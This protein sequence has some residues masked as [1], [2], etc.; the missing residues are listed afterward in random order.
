MAD[1]SREERFTVARS[2]R[3]ATLGGT[4]RVEEVW[5]VLHGYGQLA[6]FFMR[7]FADVAAP[8]RLVVAPEALSRFYL[9]LG[10]P[11]IGASWMT[12]EDREQ[13]IEDYV[14]YLDDVAERLVPEDAHL[15]VLGFSQGGATAARWSALGHRPPQ[16]VTLY[17]SEVPPDLDLAAHGTRLPNL[18]LVYGSD[19][20]YVSAERTARTE[21]RLR[22]ADVPFQTLRY[23]GDHRVLPEII[24]QLLDAA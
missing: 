9:K 12:R 5:M 13:E 17:A 14:A 18:T 19:D 7:P 3:I 2:A 6:R 16:R 23:E 20:P 21:E 8:E 10:E 4:G 11:R 24:R 1:A 22:A 15:H